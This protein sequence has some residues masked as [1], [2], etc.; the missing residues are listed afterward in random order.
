MK[1]FGVISAGLIA[2][3]STPVPFTFDETADLFGPIEI[4]HPTGSPL[5]TDCCS[6][7]KVSTLT[8]FLGALRTFVEHLAS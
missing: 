3:E 4:G 6:T 1:F 8:P 2:S 7:L 5:P